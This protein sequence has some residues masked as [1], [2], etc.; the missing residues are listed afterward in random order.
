M[1]QVVSAL[2]TF[3][4]LILDTGNCLKQPPRPVQ[5]L[6][7]GPRDECADKTSEV[8]ASPVESKDGVVVAKSSERRRPFKERYSGS[9]CPTSEDIKY[10]MVRVTFDSIDLVLVEEATALQL[11]V[12]DIGFLYT[13]D[14]KMD[15]FLAS[16]GKI[17]RFDAAT[18]MILTLCRCCNVYHLYEYSFLYQFNHQVLALLLRSVYFASNEIVLVKKMQS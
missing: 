16:C 11:E 4:L 2:N 3:A 18:Y 14:K 9:L 17:L 13:M 7:G 5:C 12:K 1:Y 6:H 10:C 15:N 8:S